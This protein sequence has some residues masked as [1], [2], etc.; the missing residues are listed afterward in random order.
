MKEYDYLCELAVDNMDKYKKA[1]EE[2]GEAYKKMKESIKSKASS[3]ASRIRA[4]KNLANSFPNGL[5][6]KETGDILRKQQEYYPE[7][8]DRFIEVC[9][10]IISARIPYYIG[11]LDE[12]GKNAWLV[13][14]QN[15]KYSYEDTMKQSGNKAVDEHESIKNGN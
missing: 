9:T 7:I 15:F 12:K 10:S 13:K 14:N 6:V 4:V 3:K 5:Y 1:H 8:T 2:G 11:P